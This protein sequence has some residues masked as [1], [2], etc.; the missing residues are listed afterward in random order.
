MKITNIVIGGG[1]VAG[2]CCLGA[3]DEI[4]VKRGYKL[5]DVK[6]FIGTSIGAIIVTILS[7][8][9][10]PTY[11]MDRMLNISISDLKDNSIGV[12]RDLCRLIRKYGYNKGDY[13]LEL[14]RSALYDL[15]EESHLTFAKH[16]AITGKN[17]I[18]TGTNVSTK[19]IVYFN[20]LTHPDMEVALAV[21]ISMSIPLFYVPISYTNTNYTDILGA[22]GLYVDGGIVDNFPAEFIFT[23]MYDMLNV[24]MDG[25]ADFDKKAAI[26]TALMDLYRL[27]DPHSAE[28]DEACDSSCQDAPT[29]MAPLENIKEP[30]TKSWCAIMRAQKLAQT[31]AIKT[32]TT[33]TIKLLSADTISSKNKHIIDFCSSVI[34]IFMNTAMRNYVTQDL[35]DAALKIDI[36]AI[37]STDFDIDTDDIMTM[38]EIGRSAAQHFIEKIVPDTV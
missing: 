10:D 32:M 16:Y 26:R 20:R 19:Q 6:N 30:D 12:I 3:L 17:L 34:D 38:I 33:D 36:G 11:V 1:G 14:I 21:R 5:A 29:K 4:F 35:W 25:M 9:S 31:L 15:T 24:D 7:C 8:T 28:C 23:K 37:S 2:F 13:A 27:R 22:T 18:I